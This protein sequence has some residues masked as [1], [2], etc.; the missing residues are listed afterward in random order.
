MACEERLT[1]LG[2]FIF[3]KRIPYF[4]LQLADWRKVEARG[5]LFLEVHSIKIRGNRHKLEHGKC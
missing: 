2:L 4:C 5:R 3:K 1:K